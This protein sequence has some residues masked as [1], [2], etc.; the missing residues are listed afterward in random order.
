MP[1]S[2]PFCFIC[3]KSSLALGYH[4]NAGYF[5]GFGNSR[6]DFAFDIGTMQLAF[7]YQHNAGISIILPV[8]I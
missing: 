4:A 3:A 1:L 2:T 7:S 5:K 6:Q 8:R